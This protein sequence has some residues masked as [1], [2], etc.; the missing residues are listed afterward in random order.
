MTRLH[1]RLGGV[2]IGAL[3]GAAFLAVYEVPAR[4]AILLVLLV[5]WQSVGG[6]V[7]WQRIR[8]HSRF[9]EHV[10]IGLSLGTALAA[11]AGVITASLGLGAWGALLPT[12]F[13]SL[14]TLIVRKRGSQSSPQTK[15]STAKLVVD[16]PVFV[17]LAVT[18]VAGLA[19]LMYSLRQ[20]P[21][22]WD[23]TWSGYHPDMPFFEAMG[24][25]IA[26]FGPLQSPFVQD[27]LIR[28]HWLS[29]AWTGQLT[30][31]SGAEPFVALTRVLPLT[32]L[33]GGAALVVSWTRRLSD[34]SWTPTLAGLLLTI[35]GFTGAVFGGVLTMDSPSQSMSVLWLIGFSMLA[36]HLMNESRASTAKLSLL[37]VFALALVGGKVSA[38]APAL[39]AVLV[40][41]VALAAMK[42]ATWQRAFAV[43]GV[44]LLG[45]GAGF[46]I[47][48]AGASGGGGLTL[49]SLIDKASSQQGL[50]PLDGPRGVLIGTLILALAVLPRWAGV[51]WLFTSRAWR[52]RAE[53]WFALG[54]TASSVLALVAF[55]SF[56]EIW[57]SSTVSGPLAVL[58][59]VGA[60]LAFSTLSANSR[61]KSAQLLVAMAVA[62]AFIYLV[63]AQ[64]WM[65]GASGG[66]LFVPTLRWMSPIAA[67]LLALLAGAF[68]ARWAQSRWNVIG[69][70]AAAIILLVISAVPGR[71]LGAGTD[72][73]AVLTNG[74][75]SEWFSTNNVNRTPG[76]DKVVD[77]A[78]HRDQLDAA[79]FLREQ[80]AA[81]DVIA[82][83][84][85]LSPLVSAL[86]HRP[87]F[88]SGIVY[89][90]PYGTASL[91]PTLMQNE[92]ESWEFIDTPSEKTLE[93]LCDAGA[94]W[95]WVDPMRTQ[96]TNW[97]PFAKE[98]LATDHV[99]LLAIDESFCQ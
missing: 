11:L 13:I 33:G 31:L 63:T 2:A 96:R 93:P 67:I 75:R 45:T 50:N 18:L 92:K 28:Y 44:T 30:A 48:V 86:T 90:A 51:A 42:K 80:A 79:E 25:S 95:L 8:P 37:A 29:Y 71:L 46:M 73:V 61:V 53:T 99:M 65:T 58:S 43:G 1:V 20:Y 5:G 74:I 22:V 54:L 39:A 68:L 84:I 40:M 7:L 26:Q 16:K 32:A 14:V 17:A 98:V 49:G 64:L 41:A 88:V 85:T 89:Q 47:F 52:S 23:G 24:Y 76:L 19:V 9:L 12:A 97:L 72:Q 21:L 77:Y 3:A 83:N 15:A 10:G 81:T 91:E 87:T 27:G 78:W 66:N 82:T 55:N 62:S 57:F 36:I 34:Q 4:T 94:R 70:I 60:G 38:A 59:A 56:N 35:G 6:A 69:S